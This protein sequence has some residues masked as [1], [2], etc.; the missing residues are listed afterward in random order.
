MTSAP[1]IPILFGGLFVWG[2]YRRVR[3]NIG[4]QTLRPRRIMVSIVIFSVVSILFS[5][6]R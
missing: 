5:S 3:R 4:Q 2:I 1:V 6:C